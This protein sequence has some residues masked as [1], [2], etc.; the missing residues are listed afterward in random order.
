MPLDTFSFARTKIQPPRLRADLLPRPALAQRLQQG[1]QKGPQQARLSLLVAPGGFGK[2]SLLLQALAGLQL[3]CAWLACE[4][5]DTL[6]RW[7]SSLVAAL[8][9]FDLPWRQS[10]EALIAQLE[11]PEGPRALRDALVNALAASEGAQGLIVL[12]DAHHLQDPRLLEFLAGLLER[13]PGSWG[14]AWLGRSEPPWS[15]ARW[16]AAG[17]LLELRQDRLRFS[18]A[19][20]EQLCQAAGQ[21]Q[22]EQLLA[23]TEGWPVG[24]SLALGVHAGVQG[25]AGP[26]RSE[27]HVLDYL[28]HEVL[29][30][31]PPPLREFLVQ[32][33]VLPELSALRCAA[34]SGQADAE[35]FLDEIERRGLFFQEVESSERTLRLHDLFR[36]A[37]ALERR[38]LSPEQQRALWQ[39]AAAGESDPQRRFHYLLQAED[40]EAAIQALSA[41]AP[42]LITAG[43]NDAVQRM[44][45]QVPAAAAAESPEL[46]LLQGLIAWE[47]LEVPRMLEQMRRAVALYAARGDADGHEL[48]CAYAGLALNGLSPIGAPQLDPAFAITVGPHTAPRTRVIHALHQAWHAFDLGDCEGT[49]RHYHAVLEALAGE[50]EP[51]LWYQVLPGL[52]LLGV[53]PLEAVLERYAEAALRVAGDDYPA[54]RAVALTMQG[55]A[56]LWRGQLASARTALDEAADL[57]A[58]TNRPHNVCVYALTTRLVCRTAQGEFTA[59]QAE[60]LREL[61]QM[62][63]LEHRPNWYLR[64]FELRCALL[65]DDWAAAQAIAQA[66]RPMLPPTLRES[67]T[68]V[69]LCIDAYSAWLAGDGVRATTLLDEALNLY[70]ELDAQGIASALRVQRAALHLQAGEPEAAAQKVRELL[71]LQRRGG[72]ALG[73]RMGRPRHLAAL[74]AAGLPCSPKNSR[75]C[76]PCAAKPRRPAR[77]PLPAPAPA[78]AGPNEPLSAREHEV[79]ALL[80]AGES[81]KLIARRLELSPHTV[82]RHV[83]NI[84]GKLGVDSRGQAAA[85]FHAGL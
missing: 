16:R 34:V 52:A 57:A 55:G 38:R 45:G 48:A 72:Y 26:L 5:A 6:G 32:C 67:H 33:S 1:L 58:W 8:E 28:R 60:H 83:A 79:L 47:R 46:A 41:A 80:A 30:A 35:R 84:L 2:S 61:Q 23:R 82:K 18:L 63:G 27:R 13:L 70:G 62:G 40:P 37:L 56:A 50:R 74:A 64:W 53:R 85:R 10:P 78:G 17:E 81:N 68:G 19:E 76:R 24:V 14:L 54:L 44:V 31:L 20:I 29:D 42:T 36:D 49:A 43:L 15:L 59:A 69:Q 65:A 73:A 4:E 51:A 21:G 39:R 9:P 12:D 71:A 3:R 7:A 75:S 66:L 25:G 11:A 77:R 22:A